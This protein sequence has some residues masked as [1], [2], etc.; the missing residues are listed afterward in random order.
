MSFHGRRFILGAAMRNFKINNKDS[1]QDYYL[2]GNLQD[3]RYSVQNG[4]YEDLIVKIS[5]KGQADVR[6]VAFAGP[7]LDHVESTI[8]QPQELSENLNL[9]KWLK[10]FTLKSF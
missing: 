8:F 3:F 1:F 5:F 9:D 10:D 2:E 4:K 6:Q 7:V